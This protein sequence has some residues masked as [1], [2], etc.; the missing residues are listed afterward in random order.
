V[1]HIDLIQDAV[2]GILAKLPTA[3]L[4]PQGFDAARIDAIILAKVPDRSEKVKAPPQAIPTGRWTPETALARFKESNQKIHAALDTSL[5]LRARV[6]NHPLFGPWHGYHWI[7]GCGLHTA[8]H[9]QQILEVKSD[10]GFPPQ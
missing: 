1:E 5:D 10:P 3:A 2:L 8:R 9:T 6:V 4:P 7:L